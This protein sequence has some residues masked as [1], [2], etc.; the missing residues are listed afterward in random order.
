MVYDYKS[1]W[2]AIYMDL[3]DADQTISSW[4]YEAIWVMYL[5]GTKVKK[6]LPDFLVSC[7]DGRRV[8]VEVKPEK[9]RSNPINSSKRK[10]VLQKCNEEGWDYYEW[11]HGQPTLPLENQPL[12]S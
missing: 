8:L 3:L 6:Y 1:S 11:A 9:M 7:H 4:E 5:N 12:N 2:E 10:A